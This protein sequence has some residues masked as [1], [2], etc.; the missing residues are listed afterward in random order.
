MEQLTNK[1]MSYGEVMARLADLMKIIGMS[2][3]ELNVDTLTE[4]KAD[5]RVAGIVLANIHIIEKLELFIDK[6]HCDKMEQ[7][8]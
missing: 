4:T 6:V 2:H 8:Y 1:Y 7:S 3:V 5:C